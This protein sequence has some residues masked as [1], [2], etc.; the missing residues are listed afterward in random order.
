LGPENSSIAGVS[1]GH[2]IQIDN[3][4]AATLDRINTTLSYSWAR[5]DKDFCSSAIYG[6]GPYSANAGVLWVQ[7]SNLSLQCAANALDNQDGNTIQV[8]NSIVQGWA[9]F[10]VRARTVYQLNTVQLNGVYEEEDGNCNPLGTGSAGLI[11]E[12]GQGHTYGGGLSG[13]LPVYSNTGTNKYFYYVVVHSSTLG[14]SPVYLAGTA[15]SDG[16][17][18]IQVLW[19]RVGTAGV[20]TYD[21][22]RLS[23]DG[24]TDMQAPYGT[25]AYAVALGVPTTSCSN[26]V[27]SIT[28]N[29]ATPL[30]SY[31]VA[32]NTVYWPSLKLWP[33]T[34]ILTTPYDTQNTG[35]GSPTTFFTD[36]LPAGAIVNS[37]G[38]TYPSVF[39]QECEPQANWT[40]VWTQCLGGNSVG[41]D[42]GE[43]TGTLLQLSSSQSAPGGLK[44]RLIFEMPPGAEVGPTHVITLSDSNPAKT[45]ATPNNRPSW[46]ATDTYIGYDGGYVPTRMGLSFGAPVSI[47]QYIGNPGDGVSYLERLT[48]TAKVF[49]VPVQMPRLLTGTSSNT[50]AA[51]VLNIAGGISASYTFTGTYKSPPSCSLTPLSDPTETG[52]FWETSTTTS[53]TANTK[54]PGTISFSYQCWGLN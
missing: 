1:F 49:N 4:Q 9:Q 12:G 24:G 32:Q 47:S 20:I 29:P 13:T 27:C 17:T 31:T 16:A 43:V 39:A 6:P 23:G 37:A 2:L 53:L 19:N 28:D 50:D 44:G 15:L 51:G 30:S 42:L 21:I 8:T 26:L 52:T 10:G 36:S 5:C 11:V 41:N 34:L 45:L 46:D 18:P 35:G 22:L 14:V 48:A 7:N 33:G 3:D 40:A 25:A 54:L 38:N